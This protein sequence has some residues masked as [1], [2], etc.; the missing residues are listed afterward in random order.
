MAGSVAGSAR[1]GALTAPAKIS[2]L[3]HIESRIIVMPRSSSRRSLLHKRLILKQVPQ[4][5]KN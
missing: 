4:C 1:A 2:P 5:R 3:N